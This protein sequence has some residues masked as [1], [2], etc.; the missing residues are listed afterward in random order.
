LF[1]G[2]LTL[3]DRGEPWVFTVRL[4][5]DVRNPGR[6]VAAILKHLLRK[7]GV[8]CIAVGRDA[9]LRRL[10]ALVESMAARIAAQS[11]LLGQPAERPEI[12]AGRR[13]DADDR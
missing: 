11:E 8:R 4:P 9:E 6:F 2:G 1:V 7:W 13:I 12:A 10:Q 3:D 5:P